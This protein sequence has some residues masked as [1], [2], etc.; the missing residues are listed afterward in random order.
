MGVPAFFRWLKEKYP[1]IL[2]ELIESEVVDL[3][4][5][6]RVPPDWTKPNPNGVEFDNLYIDM[7]G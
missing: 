2:L 5:G 4:D 1:K 7:N 6:T 3:P